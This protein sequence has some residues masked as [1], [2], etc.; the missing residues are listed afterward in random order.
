[1]DFLSERLCLKIIFLVLAVMIRA[2]EMKALNSGST[3]AVCA[4][5][6]LFLFVLLMIFS[7]PELN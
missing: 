4:I 5:S 6:C 7:K 1:M 3:N 2:S